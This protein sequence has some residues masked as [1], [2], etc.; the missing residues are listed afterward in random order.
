MPTTNNTLC[1]I[2]TIYYGITKYL[3]TP[4]RETQFAHVLFS[5]SQPQTQQ[6]GNLTLHNSLNKHI[7]SAY[8]I[9]FIV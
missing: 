3:Y 1:R 4:G 7:K 6:R 2:G 8:Q 9:H 5:F